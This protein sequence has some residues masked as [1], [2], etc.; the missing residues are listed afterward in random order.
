MSEKIVKSG[1]S[2]TSDHKL[3]YCVLKLKSEN[4]TLIYKDVKMK[5]QFDQQL[6]QN[7]L[8]Q[9]LWWVSNLFDDV[10]NTTLF[11]EFMYKEIVN[12]FVNTRKATVRRRSLHWGN[13]DIKKLMNQR[14]KALQKWQENRE[15]VS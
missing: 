8:K 4:S 5:G 10:D 3:V 15:I 11:W 6:F 2:P 12:D 13:R 1:A 9:A 14:N 7:T